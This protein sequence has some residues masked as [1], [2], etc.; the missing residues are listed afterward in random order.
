MDSGIA[1]NRSGQPDRSP[2]RMSPPNRLWHLLTVV[3]GAAV[4]ASIQDDHLRMAIGG[5]AGAFVAEMAYL[6]VWAA[7]IGEQEEKQRLAAQCPSPQLAELRVKVDR[8][9]KALVVVGGVGGLFVMAESLSELA[10]LGGLCAVSISGVAFAAIW[11]SIGRK[12]R[13]LEYVEFGDHS[14]PNVRALIRQEIDLAEYS[15]RKTAAEAADARVRSP[16]EPPR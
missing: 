12:R 13:A 5:A 2:S 1:M 3:L 8:W 9:Y 11:L 16:A 10:Y 14:D 15:R 4:G 7:L 6:F